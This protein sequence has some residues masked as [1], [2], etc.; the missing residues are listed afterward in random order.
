MEFRGRVVSADGWVLEFR[1]AEKFTLRAA[2][3]S[4]EAFIT[5]FKAEEH[6]F[7]RKGHVHHL[8]SPTG[9]FPDKFSWKLFYDAEYSLRDLLVWTY[10]LK[11]LQRMFIGEEVIRQV[12]SYTWYLRNLLM[13]WELRMCYNKTM[14]DLDALYDECLKEWNESSGSPPS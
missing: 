11:D 5:E 8:I 14:A 4:I 13:E 9:L 6:L 1:E 10:N 3:D 2:R 12:T 7:G